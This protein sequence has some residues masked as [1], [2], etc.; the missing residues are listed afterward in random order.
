MIRSKICSLNLAEEFYDSR[1]GTVKNYYKP[2]NRG[3]TFNY[4]I[5]FTL[6]K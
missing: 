2:E 6:M 1:V 5:R 3:K 4:T